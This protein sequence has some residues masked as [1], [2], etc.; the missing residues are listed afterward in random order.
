MIYPRLYGKFGFSTPLP[1]HCFNTKSP[2]IS[3]FSRTEQRRGRGH[4]APGCT[5]DVEATAKPRQQQCIIVSGCL[6]IGQGDEQLKSLHIQGVF[7]LSAEWLVNVQILPA[8]QQIAI[9][10]FF[11]CWVRKIYK[12]ILCRVYTAVALKDHSMQVS[13]EERFHVWLLSQK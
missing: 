5:R 13:Y 3:C 1:R 2:L 10:F 6:L 9:V 11:G 7:C 4:K 12:L 8:T